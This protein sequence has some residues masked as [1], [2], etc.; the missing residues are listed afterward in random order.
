VSWRG[1]SPDTGL[2][3]LQWVRVS[4]AGTYDFREYTMWNVRG[5]ST[6]MPNW[7]AHGATYALRVFAMRADWDGLTHSNQNVTPHSAIV[8]FTL[9]SCNP[10]ATTT[11][12]T[13][14]VAPATC[15][16]GGTCVVGDT[17]PGGGIVFYVH[18][19][20]GTFSCGVALT[21]TC[22]YLEAARSDQTTG[23]GE[24][25]A[26][27][28]SACYANASDSATSD[29]RSNSVYPNSADQATSRTASEGIGRGMSNT[30]QIYSRLT[31]VGGATAA[32]Y[33][34]GIAW[35]YSN[36]S[37]TDWYLPS[38]DEL[39]A[40]FSQRSV[41]GAFKDD[42]YW[43]SSEGSPSNAW[44]QNFTLS[45]RFTFSKSDSSHVRP[46]RAFGGTLACADG[47]AC[48]VG[49]T[50]PGGG[51]VFYVH[52]GGGTFSCGP[53]LAA[54]CRYLEAAPTSG[55]NAWTGGRY[56]W[57]GDTTNPIGATAQG[58]NVGTG[59]RNTEAIVA[60]SS[61]ANRAGTI[62]RAYRGPNN[63]TDWYLPSRDE[64]NELCKYARGQTT[65]ATGTVCTSSGSI[66]TGFYSNDYWSSSESDVFAS[67]ARAQS[68]SSGGQ[69]SG[70][71]G[72]NLYVFPIRAFG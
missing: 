69:G 24:V 4:A 37:V 44:R 23:I 63:L 46:I 38:K 9:P 19:G 22:R 26:T 32:S 58:T 13:T 60:Q 17:G 40:L 34:A 48:V 41:V 50:G 25:W 47:A 21:S 71:K 42:V 7:L 5:T 16:Q 10:P 55:T 11:T 8:T 36:N 53:T 14:T 72:L 6:A 59:Y 52:S 30:A 70:S 28:V 15:A 1:A 62:S 66:R 67:D 33:A 68:F 2:Y 65:G 45:N 29:C 49:D 35:A 3:S 31:D 27:N 20:G 43:S 54:T 56:F 18:P 64:L 57:S 39:D 61:T 12:T 51:I